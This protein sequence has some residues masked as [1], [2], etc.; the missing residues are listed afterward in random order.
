[1]PSQ[2]P[3]QLGFWLQTLGLEPIT[4]TKGRTFPWRASAA[5]GAGSGT[6][7]H[8]VPASDHQAGR[9]EEEGG[10]PTLQKMS[11]QQNRHHQHGAPEA[12]GTLRTQR[13][14]WPGC[15]RARPSWGTESS[16]PPAEASRQSEAHREAWHKATPKSQG[17]PKKLGTTHLARHAKGRT[18][19]LQRACHRRGVGAAY[20]LDNPLFGQAGSPSAACGE[21][22]T[23]MREAA[24]E[25]PG[26][27]QSLPT[28]KHLPLIHCCCHGGSIWR[29]HGRGP[30]WTSRLP[31]QESQLSPSAPRSARGQPQ[32]T[33]LHQQIVATTRAA[34]PAAVQTT[35]KP[36][37]EDK[38]DLERER[39][40]TTPPPHR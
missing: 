24:Q 40:S 28:P 31:P 22:R 9:K 32:R 18:G 30:G 12:A 15:Q 19:H 26:L 27:P 35:I 3:H 21:R 39:Q 38:G 4:A 11:Y 8:S 20:L 33:Y 10:T 37:R 1:M 2:P 34:T 5:S 23:S 6:S 13:R 36:A 17:W 29:Q 25:L 7:G 16:L 14:P